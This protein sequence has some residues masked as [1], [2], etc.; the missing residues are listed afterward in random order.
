MGMFPEDSN[1]SYKT[2]QIV[3]SVSDKLKN[4]KDVLDYSTI[5]DA[6]SFSG[7]KYVPNGVYT[8]T[9]GSAQL[10]NTYWGN[11]QIID[12]AGNKRAK[13]F[14][15]VKGAPSSLGSEN[16]IETAFNGDL[17]K[18]NFSVEHR[19]TGSDTAGQ[20]ATGYL[21]RPEITPH[22]TFLYNSSGWNQSTTTSAGRT[23]ICAYR[24]NVY[25]A[26]QGDV[27]AYNANVYCNSTKVGSTSFLANPAAVLF[28]GDVSSGADGVYLN[29]YE[30]GMTDNGYDVA[31]VGHVVKMNRTNSTGA[32]SAWWAGYRAQS[33]GSVPID[34][35]YSAYGLMSI[36]LDF[37]FVTLPNSGTYNN[38]AIT[39]KA[40]QRIYGNSNGTD[41][42]GL[43]RYP[44]NLNTDY[45][46]YSSSLSAWN[47]VVGNA[48]VLQLYS[49]KVGCNRSLEIL[50]AGDGIGIKSGANCKIGVA[51][52]TAGSVTV[53]NTSVTANSVIIH[54]RKTVGGIA[55]HLSYTV[56]AGASFTITSTSNTD[57]S[58]VDWIIVEKL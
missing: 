21:Y 9:L 12:S 36:G 33:I 44:S 22:Y 53:S 52:L 23:G 18:V 34:V 4:F 55:G 10:T 54:S 27:V 56:S 14:S 35:G 45:F 43:G 49:T 28:N 24:T 57:T 42:S 37:S 48:S 30:I 51:T 19:I 15:T 17:S 8:T 46:T 38:A 25:H 5:A 13:Y 47:F 41:T 2:D 16:S 32:K 20:P 1:K 26:G 39:L 11:G 40:D 58:V 3:R 7:A 31:G 6:D 29:P 50:R